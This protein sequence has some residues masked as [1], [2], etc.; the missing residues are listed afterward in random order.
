MD[1]RI[2][3]P[4]LQLYLD[5]ELD[6]SSIAELESHI[7]GC[8]DCRRELG[9][10][11]E[12]R[13]AVREIAPRYRAPAALRAR[14]ASLAGQQ[15]RARRDRSRAP[16]MVFAASMAAAM[17]VSFATALWVID[18]GVDS[19]ASENLVV[20]DLV[21]AHLRALAAASPVDVVSS[22]RHTVK[23]WFAGR[24]GAAPPVPDFAAQG[25]DLVGG[26]IDY[27]GERRVAA[28]VYRHRQ[29]LIDVYFLPGA[30]TTPHSTE[31]QR[32]GYTLIRADIEGQAAWIVSD[33]DAQE[34]RDFERLLARSGRAPAGPSSEGEQAPSGEHSLPK[35]TSAH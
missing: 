34:L 8:P 14:V 32:L 30:P 28:V 3:A 4:L 23:P 1:C 9:L 26:R 24:I 11:D 6:R 18:A 2:A 16:W 10:L 19:G 35:G 15:K 22:D 7:D 31:V 21:A 12:V 20:R 5:G 27:V 33:L 17:L 25:F 29:H 13:R